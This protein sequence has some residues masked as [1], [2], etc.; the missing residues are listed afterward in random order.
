MEELNFN[1]TSCCILN[2]IFFI[3]HL[4]PKQI[5]ILMHGYYF[6]QRSSHHIGFPVST[7]GQTYTHEEP[8][9][10]HALSWLQTPTQFTNSARPPGVDDS[11]PLLSFTSCWFWL[12]PFPHIFDFIFLGNLR[13]CHSQRRVC[14]YVVLDFIIISCIQVFFNV[15]TIRVLVTWL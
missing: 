13:N 4:K 15:V 11:Q 12:P 6:F 9:W 14:S 5:S 3:S 8:T 10:S 1:E 7:D 2:P